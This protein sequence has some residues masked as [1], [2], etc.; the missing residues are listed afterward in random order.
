MLAF[1]QSCPCMLFLLSYDEA[2]PCPIYT[3][4]RACWVSTWCT[5]D[6][7]LSPPKQGSNAWHL[8]Y[9]LRSLTTRTLKCLMHKIMLTLPFSESMQIFKWNFANTEA[10]CHILQGA[11]GPGFAHLS[12][13]ATADIQ[14]LCNIFPIL[15]LQLIK[16]SLFKQFLVLKK[17]IWAW[18]SMEC[19]H[20]DKLLITFQQ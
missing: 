18:Q 5:N 19:D 16:G 12:D 6:K 11:Q 20:L 9:R 10:V 2:F 15:S 7:K 4:S 13:M 1:V 17:N 14:M 3:Q 8:A